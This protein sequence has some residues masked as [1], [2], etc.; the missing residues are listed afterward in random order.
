MTYALTRDFDTMHSLDEFCIR[1]GCRKTK[2]YDLIKSGKLRAFKI[3][4]STRIYRSKW[5][6]SAP[7]P[8]VLG[9]RHPALGSFGR[10]DCTTMYNEPPRASST[11]LTKTVP[12]DL[13]RAH[14]TIHSHQWIPFQQFPDPGPL[15]ESLFRLWRMGFVKLDRGLNKDDGK[16]CA[17]VR[18]RLD[19]EPHGEL[20][21]AEFEERRRA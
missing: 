20:S 10:Q 4:G 1:F 17:I 3:K 21:N 2:A 9:V 11:R 16:I 18:P 6:A 5:T 8:L 13:W 15:G 7:K 14:T 12:P 19:G